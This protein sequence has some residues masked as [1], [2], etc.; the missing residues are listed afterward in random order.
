MLYVL[1]WTFFFSVNTCFK[2]I[3]RRDNL[4]DIGIYSSRRTRTQGVRSSALLWIKRCFQ[5]PLKIFVSSQPVNMQIHVK[6]IT[7]WFEFIFNFLKSWR[8]VNDHKTQ[9]QAKIRIEA[10]YKVWQFW[11]FWH[12]DPVYGLVPMCTFSCFTKP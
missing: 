11:Q 9:L 4:K 8:I 2:I 1:D 6:A 3:M 10:C 12:L 5:I 7:F